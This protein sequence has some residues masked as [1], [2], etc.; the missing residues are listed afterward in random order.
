MKR[1]R[2]RNSITQIDLKI[3]K[4]LCI[5]K[6]PNIDGHFNLFSCISDEIPDFVLPSLFQWQIKKKREKKKETWNNC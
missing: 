2:L 3:N 5:R 1:R 4:E 6:F